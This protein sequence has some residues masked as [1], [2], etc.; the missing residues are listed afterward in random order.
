[1][2]GVYKARQKSLGRLVAIRMV[3]AGEFAS[4]AE[5]GRFKAVADETEAVIH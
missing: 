3:L 2:G 4:P 5:L 1:M